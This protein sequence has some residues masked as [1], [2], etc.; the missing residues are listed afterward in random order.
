MLLKVMRI[1]VIL[2]LLLTTNLVCGQV[3]IAG[4]ITD[5]QDKSPL[6]YASV[7]IKNS[8][9]GTITNEQGEFVLNIPNNLIKDSLLVDFLGYSTFRASIASLNNRKKNNIELQPD[10][11]LLQEVVISA[12]KGNVLR[13]IYEALTNI[14]NT[15]HNYPLMY[16]AFYREMSRL[17]FNEAMKSKKHEIDLGSGIKLAEA[18]FDIYK[19]AYTG[20]DS[21]EDVKL[22]KG[23]YMEPKDFDINTDT[24]VKMVLEAFNIEGGPLYALEYDVDNYKEFSFFRHPNKYSYEL[25]SVVRKA[26]RDVYVIEFDQRPELKKC[27]SQGHIYIDAEDMAIMGF[28]YKKSRAN[29][30]KLEKHSFFGVDFSLLD[31][32]GK[33]DYSKSEGKWVLEHVKV[34]VIVNISSEGLK[35][36][37]KW[38]AAT[39]SAMLKSLSFD[40]DFRQ[41]IELSVNSTSRDIKRFSKTEQFSKKDLVKEEAKEYDASFWKNYNIILP[42]DDLGT[43]E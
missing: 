6:P 35:G 17:R 27:L 29:S 16:R 41:L 31:W 7:H 23:R 36:P 24:L 2:Y 30:Y 3:K 43:I 22:V 28:T 19:P 4:I 20:N 32:K 15:H 14:P 38:L 21:K 33:V 18:V 5:S 12:N 39:K 8:P 1:L 10:L 37:V 42:D 25:K 11:H 40:M 9:I 26:G 34:D 13:I